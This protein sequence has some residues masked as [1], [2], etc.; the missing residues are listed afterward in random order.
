MEQADRGLLEKSGLP[1]NRLGEGCNTSVRAIGTRPSPGIADGS[2][3]AEQIE[4]IINHLT[5]RGVR[6]PALL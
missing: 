1:I 3:T 2:A 5:E 4:F 6:N